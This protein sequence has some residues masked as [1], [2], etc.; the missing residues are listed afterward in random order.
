MYFYDSLFIDGRW[1]KP[2]SNETI[3]LVSPSTEEVVG[4][5]PSAE[6]RDVDAAVAS[7]RAAFDDAHGWPNWEPAR[8]AAALEQLADELTARAD[9]LSCRVSSQNGMPIAFSRNV[10]AVTPALVLRYYAGIL[11]DT[12]FESEQPHLM[13]GTTLIRREPMGVVAAIVPWNYP[14]S[15]ASFKYAPALAAGCTVVLKP[16]PQT[17]LD[18]YTF[19]EAVSATAIPPGVVNIVGGGAEASAHLV[20]HPGVDKVAF[21]GSTEIGRQIAEVCG[22]LFRPVTLELGGKSAAI[23][24]D[25]ADLDLSVIGERLFE[26][27]LLNNGQTCFLSTRILAPESRYS[28]VVD[29]LAALVSSLRVGDALDPATQIGPM[30][31]SAHRDRVQRYI[32]KGIHE[33]ARCVV[34]GNAAR[35]DTGWFVEP[36]LFADVD[37]GAT[38]AQEEIFGP[39]LSVIGYTDTDDAV[40]IAN[41]SAYGLGGTVWTSDPDRGKPIARRI[42][43]GTVGINRYQPD[44]GA[45]FGGVRSS[46]IGRELG[47]T[48]MDNYMHVKAIYA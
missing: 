8:R 12:Q 17:L 3:A 7:A 27:T 46:G 14:Q 47:S 4:V 5:V 1:M 13:N 33:G 9:E 11:R 32:K 37:N 30:V 48:A 25:D 34:G 20:E 23:I 21:T 45:P 18:S 16:S 26:A 19:A 35:H 42:R 44:I 38:I 24:L 41:N 36:T 22:R 28:E 10:E 29:T 39:V 40:R 43:T 15:L 31:S 2:A 6:P